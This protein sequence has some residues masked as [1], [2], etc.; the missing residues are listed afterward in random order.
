M[1]STTTHG[2]NTPRRR[3]PEHTRRRTSAAAVATGGVVFPHLSLTATSILGTV[4]VH[5]LIDVGICR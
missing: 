5:L 1:P 2:G 4:T 3:A